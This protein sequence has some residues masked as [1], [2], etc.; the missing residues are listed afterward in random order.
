MSLLGITFRRPRFWE[1]TASAIMA[2]GVW[3]AILGV[4]KVS[5]LPLSRRDAGALLLVILWGS[6]S[7]RMGVRIGQ[8]PNHLAVNLL[9]SA[10]VL[11]VYQVATGV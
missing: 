3:V 1:I 11:G 4:T 5:G 10:M 2:A 7:A 6:V 8:G 9:V